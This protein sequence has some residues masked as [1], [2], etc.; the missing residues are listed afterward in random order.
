MEGIRSSAPI[1]LVHEH[2]WS[3]LRPL[4]WIIAI[5]VV[6][7]AVRFAGFFFDELGRASAQALAKWLSNSSE[8]AQSP[9]RD[10]VVTLRFEIEG[11]T[12]VYGFIP[13]L[14]GA[15]D[16]EERISVGLSSASVVASLAGLQAATGALQGAREVWLT[17]RAL[18]SSPGWSTEEWI[19]PPTQ[20]QQS[21]QAPMSTGSSSSHQIRATCTS[22]V[23]GFR[24]RSDRT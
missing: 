5:P 14:S 20:A 12:R 4:E 8:G 21:H 13:V 24:L 9:E 1:P 23:Q 2:R 15:G 11:S 7:S 18:R 10:W 17:T 22:L 6:W 16:E 3:E 19:L